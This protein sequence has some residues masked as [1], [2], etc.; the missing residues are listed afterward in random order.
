MNIIDTVTLNAPQ[1][2]EPFKPRKAVAITDGTKYFT[3]YQIAR[4]WG[5]AVESVRR[6]IRQRRLDSRIISRRRLVPVAEIDRIERE[7]HISR[8]G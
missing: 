7:G 4:R 3:P 6:A 2:A 8:A 1:Q 5:W